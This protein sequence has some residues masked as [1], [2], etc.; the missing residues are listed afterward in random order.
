MYHLTLI[1]QGSLDDAKVCLVTQYGQRNDDHNMYDNCS[2]SS[3][4]CT[5]IPGN[6]RENMGKSD[7]QPFLRAEVLNGT[8]AAAC[9]INLIKNN[10]HETLTLTSLT[11]LM[12]KK[13]L[14]PTFNPVSVL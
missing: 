1:V 8:P 9:I 7:T 12:G 13:E 6:G 2:F 10:L 5:F 4:H 14:Q 3:F 11:P